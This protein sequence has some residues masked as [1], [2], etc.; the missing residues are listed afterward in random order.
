MKLKRWFFGGKIQD[1]IKKRKRFFWTSYNYISL[2]VLIKHVFFLKQKIC[3]QISFLAFFVSSEKMCSNLFFFLKKIIIRAFFSVLRKSFSNIFC[4]N[5]FCWGRRE[6]SSWKSM[7]NLFFIHFC[8]EKKSPFHL[9]YK[10]SFFSCF[11]FVFLFFSFLLFSF[12]L[13]CRPF[14]SKKGTE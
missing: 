13:L 8:S 10:M 5:F 12:L 7:L 9:F 4:W 14:F 3:F 6:K 2:V 11:C 1:E